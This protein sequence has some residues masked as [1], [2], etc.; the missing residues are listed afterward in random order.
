MLSIFQRNLLNLDPDLLISDSVLVAQPSSWPSKS[1]KNL[2]F[3]IQKSNFSVLVLF[4]PVLTEVTKAGA[5]GV[6]GETPF[7]WLLDCSCA[8]GVG[9]ETPWITLA[10]E[11]L[12]QGR[13]T[14]KNRQTL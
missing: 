6:G 8:F 3:Q 2:G 12:A 10:K 5:F 11:D 1:F 7:V 4:G 14:K 13:C 9:G